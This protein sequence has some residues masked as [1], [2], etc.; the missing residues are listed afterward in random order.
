VLKLEY[1]AGF[2]DGEGSIGVYTNGASKYYLKTQLVQNVTPTTALFFCELANRF[3][4]SLTQRSRDGKRTV[5]SWQLN[6]GKAAA[7]LGVIGPHLL[8]KRLE[9]ELAMSWQRQR[10]VSSRDW[11]GRI[12]EIPVLPIDV[13]V[14]VELK[15]LKGSAHAIPTY[16]MQ[17]ECITMLRSIHEGVARGARGCRRQYVIAEAA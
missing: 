8:V 2:F 17:D 9:A 13:V 5:M 11:R 16:A 6:S 4:G 15:R 3:G 10:R 12:V 1:I 7:F 14:A